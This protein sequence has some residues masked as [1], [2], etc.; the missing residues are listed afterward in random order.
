MSYGNGDRY[1]FSPAESFRF[2][3]LVVPYH[4][5]SERKNIHAHCLT[6][7][8]LGRKDASQVRYR[9]TIGKAVIDF[10]LEEDLMQ[11]VVIPVMFVLLESGDVN[12]VDSRFYAVF[13][14]KGKHGSYISNNTIQLPRDIIARYNR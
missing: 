12:Q 1:F 5:F 6:H 8:F 10:R 13:S 9:I 4:Y 2:A 7:S 3:I 11:K 14:K